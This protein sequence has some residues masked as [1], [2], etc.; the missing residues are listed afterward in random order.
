MLLLCIVWAKH[1][2]IPG[3]EHHAHRNEFHVHVD[4]N[5]RGGFLQSFLGKYRR[6]LRRPVFVWKQ[7]R[8][9]RYGCRTTSK[10]RKDLCSAL[11]ATQSDRILRRL[12]LYGVDAICLDFSISWE[13]AYRHECVIKLDCSSRCHPVCTLGGKHRRGLAQ[14]L[15]ATNDGHLRKG[16][17]FTYRRRD[18]LCQALYGFQWRSPVQGLHIHGERHVDRNCECSFLW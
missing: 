12:H 14:S 16:W 17:R 4:G 9:F 2:E 13:H 11:Y 6:G 15:Y 18:R 5:P 10:R 7:N 8:N 3:A 1:D